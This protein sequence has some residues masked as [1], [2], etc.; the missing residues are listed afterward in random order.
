MRVCVS[1]RARVPQPTRGSGPYASRRAHADSRAWLARGQAWERGVNRGAQRIRLL[2]AGWVGLRSPAAG[3]LQ[4]IERPACGWAGAAAARPHPHPT[5]I[6][7]LH[8]CPALASP[9][10]PASHLSSESHCKQPRLV[11]WTTPKGTRA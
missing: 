8:T 5:P 6:P 11:S 10:R 4:S 7:P 1:M 3:V 2:F 9:P